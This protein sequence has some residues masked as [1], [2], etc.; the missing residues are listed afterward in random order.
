MMITTTSKKEIRT[1]STI[2]STCQD[3]QSKNSLIKRTGNLFT[4]VDFGN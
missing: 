4:E 3:S 1:I 2:F